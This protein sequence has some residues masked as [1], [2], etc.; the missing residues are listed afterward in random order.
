MIFSRPSPSYLILCLYLSLNSVTISDLKSKDAR[1]VS[2]KC[3]SDDDENLLTQYFY[4][5][6]N[7]LTINFLGNGN[8]SSHP[9][10]VYSLSI[11]ETA[12]K[13]IQVNYL[14]ENVNLPEDRV[15]LGFPNTFV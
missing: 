2:D 12:H 5:A 3:L 9:D 7:G 10:E 11:G 14:G 15:F 6:P 13:K 1:F 8:S 4:I